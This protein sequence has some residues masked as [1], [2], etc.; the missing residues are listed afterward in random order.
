MNVLRLVPAPL[1]K[2]FP[3]PLQLKLTCYHKFRC[4]RRWS[5]AECGSAQE[6]RAALGMGKALPFSGTLDGL[7]R[8]ARGEG[9]RAL[10][11]G[12]SVSLAMSVPMVGIYLPLYDALL[13]L[14]QGAAW[15]PLA[16]GTLSRT[17]AVL[18]TAP[19]ELVRTRLQARGV[20]GNPT[21]VSSAAVCEGCDCPL[22]QDSARSSTATSGKR[23]IARLWRGVG[24]QLARD[25]PFSALYWGMVEPLRSALMRGQPDDAASVFR[26]NVA[27]GAM[28]GAIAGAATTPLDVVKTRVQ[29]ASEDGKAPSVARVLRNVTTNEGVAGLFRGWSAR[30]GK[31][32]PACAI[33]LSAYE[34]I[35]HWHALD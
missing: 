7:W 2:P 25:V 28:A 33:V 23:S 5:F 29:V 4:C 19:F 26:C 14:G 35:K 3:N 16:A 17:A 8:I 11:R 22:G 24:S 15:A 9:A 21:P 1:L 6:A 31:A 34:G 18:A 20:V 27:A 12:T 30:A 32:A 10:W 13:S